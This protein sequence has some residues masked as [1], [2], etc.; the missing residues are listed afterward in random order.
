VN[1]TL[2][3]HHGGLFSGD[4]ATSLSFG[5]LALL[6]LL[7][8]LSFPLA[9]LSPRFLLIPLAVFLEVFLGN[10]PAKIYSGKSLPLGMPKFVF[11]SFFIEYF[12]TLLTVLSFV[13]KKP[14]W[15]R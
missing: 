5:A 4:I 13:G 3:W 2:R 10:L 8:A 1:Q 6:F 11:L 14:E 9:L 12:F 7:C 15:K